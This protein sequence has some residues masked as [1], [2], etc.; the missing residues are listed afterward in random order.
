[1]SIF[2]QHFNCVETYRH[3]TA[4]LKQRGCCIKS[5]SSALFQTC[6]R[7]D[8]ASALTGGRKSLR[9]FLQEDVIKVLIK[10]LFSAI[11]GRFLQNRHFNLGRILGPLTANTNHSCFR[12]KNRK[13]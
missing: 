13:K 1:M 2:D 7:S 11:P 6:E 4:P 9:G 8:K 10:A 12:S 5:Q 3:N